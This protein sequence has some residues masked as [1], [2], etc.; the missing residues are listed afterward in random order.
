VK[1]IYE[2]EILNYMIFRTC[3][4]YVHVT[5]K[6]LLKR[7]SYE[8]RY[9]ITLMKL[10]PGLLNKDPD[11]PAGTKYRFLSTKEAKLRRFSLT[12]IY[13]RISRGF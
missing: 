13:S 7:H 3:F 4:F 1:F 12:R 10:T 5:R 11:S 8:K 9:C 2:I 6:K